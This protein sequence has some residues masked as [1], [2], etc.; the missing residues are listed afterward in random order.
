MKHLLKNCT[1]KIFPFSCL[2]TLNIEGFFL[3]F[4][5]IFGVQKI[6]YSKMTKKIFRFSCEIFV[7][8]E[9]GWDL[10]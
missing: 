10:I 5:D 1:L 2:L 3:F 7:V 8:F 6:L 4:C 9:K